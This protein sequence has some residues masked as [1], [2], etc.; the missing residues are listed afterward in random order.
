[1]DR[2]LAADTLR[3]SDKEFGGLYAR[4]WLLLHYLTFGGA[5]EGQLAAYL[6]AINSGKSPA[7]AATVFGDLEALDRELG[8]YKLGALRTVTLNPAALAIGPV[9]VTALTPGEDA[10]MSVRLRSEAGVNRE[11][12]AGV[13]EDAKRLCGRFPNDAGAQ[14]VL[15]EAAFDA[16]DYAGAEAAAD[17]AI[18]TD[19]A[20]YGAWLYKARARMAAA[21]AAGDKR[22][23]TWSAIRKLI[24]VAN[25]GDPD[26]PEPLLVYY[27]SYTDIGQPPT[28]IAR[29]GLYRAFMLAPQVPMLRMLAARSYLAEGKPQMARMLLQPLAFSPHSNRLAQE[30]AAMIAEIYRGGPKP[31]G[32]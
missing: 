4:G 1:M 16:K 11:S 30:A 31:G 5:R 10:T 18:A 21:V 13:Y 14:L 32:G 9:T 15:A 23:E 28:P 3:L 7:E 26:N 12:A 20:R 6:A 27:W 8:R 22:P 17:R 25:R 2:M 19:P 24:G 29:Q